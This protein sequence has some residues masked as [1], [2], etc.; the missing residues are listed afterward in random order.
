MKITRIG[1]IAAFA[2]AGALALTSCAAN[3]VPGG[4]AEQPS[5]LSGTLVGAGASSQQSAQEAWVAAF[6]I[7]NPGVT[8]EYDPVGSGGGRDTFTAGGS[9]F[10]G[11]DRAFKLDEIEADDF[12]SCAAGSGIIEIPA[13]IS[14]IAVI[15][16]LDGIDSLNLDA[17]A[18]AGIFTGEI[19]RWNDPAIASQNDGVALPDLQITAVHRGDDSGT[20]ANF[21]D[22]LSVVAPEVWT[23]G[24]IES[25][26]A[27]FGGE[28][29]NQTSGM[30]DAVTNGT[31]TIGYADA[32]RAG[33]LGTVAVKVGEEYVPYS[34][35]AAAAIVDASPLEDGR[36]EFDLA[37]AL[38]RDSTA[39]GVYPIVL[40]SY[41]IACTEYAE[42]AP[43]DLLKAYLSYVVSAEGQQAAFSAAG[44]A[45]ISDSL[46]EKAV[47]AIDAIT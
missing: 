46:R 25:W 28:A 26:P 4:G 7:A 22:Y 29:A 30:V 36:G 45:P 14:P 11:S 1:G 34:P 3:E 32:S 41:L 40:I 47:A 6:Q 44:S 33:E 20:T 18:L 24:S 15:F 31:G 12:G 5:G 19:T 2:L 37:V 38:E 43:V 21:T 27:E 23:V 35:E 39:S 10:A 13:Y 42:G 17:A 8:V 9:Q 16:N